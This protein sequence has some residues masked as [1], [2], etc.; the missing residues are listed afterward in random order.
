MV[1]IYPIGW[2]MPDLKR[3]YIIAAAVSLALLITF[4]TV[5]I[6]GGTAGI[7]G[8]VLDQQGRPVPYAAV[9]AREMVRAEVVQVR[10]GA[11]GAYA[12]TNLR[13]GTYSLWSSAHGYKAKPLG[14]VRIAAGR[15][16][17]LEVVLEQ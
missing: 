13:P 12:L 17:Q 16:I 14:E 15:N 1:A 11:N 9:V 2:H 8:Q 10:A 7:R 5:P 6:P 3:L 4:S